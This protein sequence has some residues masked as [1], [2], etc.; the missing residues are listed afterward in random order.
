MTEYERLLQYAYEENIDVIEDC[1]LPE[2]Y[3][4]LYLCIQGIKNRTVIA[5]QKRLTT[6]EKACVLAEEM[7]H[8]WYSACDRRSSDPYE[9]SRSEH[10]ALCCAAEIAI[11]WNALR[12]A[13]TESNFFLYDCADLL[14]VTYQ[15][16]LSAIAHYD[17]K[18]PEEMTAFRRATLCNAAA[19]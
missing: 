7:G 8:H 2:G 18:Y 13:L 10:R 16:L 11:P 5:I 9:I 4:G 19:I 1:K 3:D 17:E 14:G 15:F 6:S 12:D